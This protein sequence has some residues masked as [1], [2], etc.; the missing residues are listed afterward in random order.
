MIDEIE[1]NTTEQMDAMRNAMLEVAE[2]YYFT[3]N[4]HTTGEKVL[5]H[6]TNMS[7]GSSLNGNDMMD[8][9]ASVGPSDFMFIREGQ[10]Q[11]IRFI[12]RM[13]NFYKES[14]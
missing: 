1:Q 6:L 2:L 12:N 8:A 14:K 11:V 3:F 5:E 9:N 10:D 7:N 13:I 4:N